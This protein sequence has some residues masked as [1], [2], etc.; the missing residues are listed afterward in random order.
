MDSGRFQVGG[1]MPNVFATFERTT[2]VAFL[3]V[4]GALSASTLR[5]A[6]G[7]NSSAMIRRLASGMRCGLLERAR[8]QRGPHNVFW[9]NRRHPAY[10]EI[11][12]LGKALGALF[13]LPRFVNPAPRLRPRRRQVDASDPLR[14]YES[15]DVFGEAQTAATRSEIL[16]FLAA[17]G[18]A[19]PISNISA[20][21]R[22][23][24]Y[25]TMG[26][27]DAFETFRILLSTYKGNQ[28]LVQLNPKW[29]A[30]KELLDLLRRLNQVEP[31]W[32]NMAE[33][34]HEVNG[35]VAYIQ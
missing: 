15:T 27:V 2:L 33:A 21:I 14:E 18:S 3:S 16:L 9:I 4:H 26:A 5:K 20:V 13:Q 35:R 34:Y 29:E 22:R 8:R 19:V 32:R 24:R 25:P 12:A 31:T 30:A 23:D 7:V 1:E 11:L 28:R 17:V 6:F 10:D